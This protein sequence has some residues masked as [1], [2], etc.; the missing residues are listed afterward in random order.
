MSLRLEAAFF[1][2]AFI[3]LTFIFVMLG[4]W[5]LRRID[6]ARELKLRHIPSTRPW[7]VLP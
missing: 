5:A 4:N 6:L 7:G 2:I 3:A 1:A